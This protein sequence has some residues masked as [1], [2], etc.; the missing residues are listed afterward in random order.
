MRRLAKMKILYNDGH[1]DE[2]PKELELEVMRH[3]AA[4]I[5][6]Q[7]VKHLY[8]EA[9]F[10][11]G[12]ATEKGFHYDI[13]F[14]DKAL[15]EEDLPAIEEEMHKIV[16]ENIPFKVYE[17]PRDEAVK[18]M[19][20]RGETYKAEH[21]GDLGE[22]ERI[23]FYQQG[24]YID[25]CTGPH[26]TYTKALKSFKLT[27]VSG[28]YWRNNRDNK[29]LTRLNGV[30]FQTKEE[31][32]DY[33]RQVAEA[34]ARD[35]RRIGKDM[36]LFMTDDLVG[37]GLPMFLPKGYALWQVLEDYIKDKERMLGYQ[38]VM[39]PCVGTVGLYETSGHWAHYKENMFPVM[40]LEDEKFVLRPMNCPHHMMIYASQQ[41]SYRDLP[42]RIG[43]IAHDFRYEP[44]GTLKGIERARHFCQ[45]DAHLFVTPEQIESEVSKVVDLIFDC[46][47]DFGITDY[48]CVLSLRDPED[49]VKYYQDD[50]MWDHAESAL[51][52]V[53]NDLGLDYTEEIG[54]A[55]FYG[56]KLD[57]NVKP[58]VGAEYTLSTCQLDFCLPARFDLK[59][60]DRDGTEKTPVVLHRAILGS[61]DRFMAYLIEET[62]G[63]FP[64]WLAPLQIKVLPVSEK[65]MEYAEKVT[66]ALKEARLRVEL[67]DRNEKIGY[68][69]RAARQEDK[70]PYMIIIGEKEV[71]EGNISVRS[72]ATDQTETFTVEEFIEKV[73]QEVRAHQ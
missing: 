62:K 65:S 27:T 45:N 59:Y 56:P 72:R 31:L 36:K 20:D 23:T 54:E 10:A 71:T 22:D 34:K 47:K 30:A 17:L 69:I 60:V 63:V 40:E 49:K 43:E 28:A 19:Q 2:C 57:V 39:T 42:I 73:R 68:K 48:R 61:L 29:M 4:H 44:S 46:Y 15:S 38:H 25:M 35:H 21:I 12:P 26:L 18:L 33:E 58:A 53:L 37:K 50:A 11:F 66:D 9:H 13:D 67:D 8:P 41:H 70:V 3:S 14:G 64:V 1:V 55:A 24:D 5:M 32:E 16:K 51:R 7:A 6:A 52:A